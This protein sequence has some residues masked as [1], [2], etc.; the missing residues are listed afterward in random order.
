MSAYQCP[1]ARSTRCTVLG[2]PSICRCS[3]I[4]RK[5]P[6]FLGTTRCFLSSCRYQSLPYCLSWMGCHLFG[7]LKRGQPIPGM[8]F[9]LAARN[10]LRDLE[11]R[12]ASICTVLAGTCSPCPLNAASSSYLLGNVPSCSYCAL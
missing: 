4:L 12:S 8:L 6:S 2:L 10:S 9:C 7:F 3:L 11:R 5:W 1:S